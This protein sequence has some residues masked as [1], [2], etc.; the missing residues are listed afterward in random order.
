MTDTDLLRIQTRSPLY[1]V[2]EIESAATID[3][4][5]LIGQKMIGMLQYAVKTNADAQSLIQLIAHFNDA[6][7]Q[8]LI[9]ILEQR[10]GY[11]SSRRCRLSGAG[12]R[13]AAGADPADRSGQRHRLSG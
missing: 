6:F 1:L 4:L 2:Q 7:T 10:D 8:R 11:P 9:F 12:E 3:Q 13:R 5:R